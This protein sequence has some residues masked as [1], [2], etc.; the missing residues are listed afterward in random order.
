MRFE[1]TATQ[2]ASGHLHS[3]LKSVEGRA[4][5]VEAKHEPRY[6][7]VTERG[8]SRFVK[9]HLDL[10][11]MKMA[12]VRQPKSEKNAAEKIATLLIEVAK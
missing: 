12:K 5:A 6:A 11:L 7:F 4:G 2:A 1:M 10:K 9:N 3:F 8:P